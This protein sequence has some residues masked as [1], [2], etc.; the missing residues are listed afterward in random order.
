MHGECGGYL[1]FGGH[2]QSN[3][4]SLFL[5]VFFVSFLEVNLENYQILLLL[6]SNLLSFAYIAYITKEMKI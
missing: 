5:S 2:L 4:H 6:L 3:Q 1:R